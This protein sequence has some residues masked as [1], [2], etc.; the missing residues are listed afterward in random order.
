MIDDAN[1]DEAMK[2]FEFPDRMVVDTTFSQ[3]QLNPKHSSRK[4]KEKNDKSEGDG[5]D[6]SRGRSKG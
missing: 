3:I 4:D 5:N 6:S 2:V 1:I